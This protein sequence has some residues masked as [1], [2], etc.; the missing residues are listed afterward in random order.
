MKKS[1]K[2]FEKMLVDYA[3]GRLSTSDSS[4]VAEHLTQCQNCVK[5]MGALQRSLELAGMIWTDGLAETENIRISASRQTRKVHRLRYAAIAASILLV[6]SVF[7]AWHALVKPVEVQKEPSFAEIERKIV[8]EGTA[9]RL[10]AATDLL[11]D[12]PNA[13][14][15]VQRQYEYIVNRY[16][17]TKAAKT[18]K[19]KIQ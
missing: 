4:E 1:C 13:K 14:T 10:L 9:A 17:N 19:A 18:A 15:L 5:V 3:D 16:P 11:A 12:K 2:E 6:V 8:N 7:V